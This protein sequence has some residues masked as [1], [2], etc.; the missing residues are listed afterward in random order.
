[1]RTIFNLSLFLIL[2]INALAQGSITNVTMSPANPTSIDTVYIYT[3]LQF[4]YGDCPLDNQSH[5]VN[6]TTI[7]ANAHHC[8]GLLT[9]IC[10]T[11]DTFKINPLPPGH[12]N[13]DFNLTS[14]S[15]AMPCTP[16]IV[17]DDSTTFSFTVDTA[18]TA[19]VHTMTLSD[20]KYYPNPIDDQVNLPTV[21]NGTAYSIIDLTGQTI[22]SGFV[23]HQTIT[24]LATLS[25]GLYFLKLNFES[26]EL[27]KRIVK[28]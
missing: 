22:Q 15:G 17:P 16:G 3:H 27:T 5:T 11:I 9:V 24:G 6:N 12:Y 21:P 1:M 20:F 4:N 19:D 7:Q 14:G 18:E 23:E 13:F 26:I 10:N 2:S 28:R 8:I 25:T